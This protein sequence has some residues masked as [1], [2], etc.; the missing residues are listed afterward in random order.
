MLPF[1]QM[2]ANGCAELALLPKLLAFKQRGNA[3]YGTQWPFK[4]N[5]IGQ[6]VN[7]EIM[8]DLTKTK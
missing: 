6:K 1:E 7:Q 3:V 8:P 2:L 4:A 5:T